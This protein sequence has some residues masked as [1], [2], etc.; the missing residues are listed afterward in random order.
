MM[1][2]NTATRTAVKDGPHARAAK[3]HPNATTSSTA[4]YTTEMGALQFRHFPPSQIQPRMGT[5]SCHLMGVWQCGQRDGGRMTD[6]S[7]GQRAMHTFR[8]E[9]ITAPVRKKNS[10]E[11]Q[12]VTA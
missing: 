1:V 5:L 9:P 10:S 12:S 4:G 8:K 3:S 6:S 11:T 7:A 2:P